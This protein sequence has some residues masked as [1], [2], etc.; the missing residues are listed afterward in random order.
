M[1]QLVLVLCLLLSGL[2]LFAQLEDR[3]MVKKGNELYQQQKYKEAEQQYRQALG[4]KKSVEGNFNL[5]DAQYKQKQ[6]DKAA[7]QF[8]KLS[9]SKDPNVAAQAYHNLGN[10]NMQG[11]KLEESIQAYEKSLLNNPK[12]E[13]T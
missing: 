10:I 3:R 12:D 8:G 13:Q 6:Y 9:Q 4:T 1:K 11:N 7:E 2:Q 5:G